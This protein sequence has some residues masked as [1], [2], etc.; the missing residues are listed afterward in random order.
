M[1]TRTIRPGTRGVRGKFPS[2]KVG[3]MVA[4]ESALERD[5]LLLLEVDP[6][7]ASYEEQPTT[8]EYVVEGR[9]R[10]YTPDCLVRHVDG[11]VMLIEVKYAADV[12]EM[13]PSRRARAEAAW[14]AAR[15]YAAARGWDFRVET[16]VEIRSPKLRRAVALRRFAHAPTGTERWRE[17]VLDAVR[18]KP[19]I[20]ISELV[21]RIDDESADAVVRHLL[22]LGVLDSHGDGDAAVGDNTKLTRGGR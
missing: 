12:A 22:W 19:G 14:S 20:T 5:H 10:R 8:I 1:P 21:A 17:A 16:D 13:S 6:M 3:R 7:V 4:F 9:K 18:E 15:E 11:S 2:R